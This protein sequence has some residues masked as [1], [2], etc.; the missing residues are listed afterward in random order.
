M[1]ELNNTASQACCSSQRHFDKQS[2][3]P[4]ASAV[5]ATQFSVDALSILLNVPRF[6][7][8]I[9]LVN[10]PKASINNLFVTPCIYKKAGRCA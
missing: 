4:S 5:D 9:D 2:K 10:L 7:N 3:H 8:C 1:S 6:S